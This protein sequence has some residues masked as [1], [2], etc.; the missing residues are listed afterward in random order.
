MISY[1][2]LILA[3]VLTAG[4]LGSTQIDPNNGLHIN[5]FSADPVVA[6]ADDVVRLLLDIENIGGTTAECVTAELFGVESWKDFNGAPLSYARPW[7]HHGISFGLSGDSFNFCYYDAVQG[8]ICSGYTKDYGVSFSSFFGGSF[9]SFSEDLC[10]SYSM[11]GPY[12]AITKT[13]PQLT[14]P[15]PE[16]NKPGQSII[17]EWILRPPALSEGLRVNYPITARTSYFY[18]SNAHMNIRVFNK[19]EFRRR[20]TIGEPISFPLEIVNTHASPIQVWAVDGPNPIIINTDP[21]I[22]G[23]DELENFRFQLVNTG[24]GFPLPIRDVD[25]PGAIGPDFESGFIFGTMTIS[26]PG[27]YF[28]DSFGQQGKEIILSGEILES[29]L[30]LRSDNKAPIGLTIGIDKSQW[31][32]TPTGTISITFNLWYR[33]Y[34]DSEVTVN[35]IGVEH[36]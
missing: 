1:A 7:R 12:D 2:T 5:E 15:L 32:G 16:R 22:G 28:Y 9:M 20:E 19:D 11:L 31:L 36:L 33:Y 8:E 10:R 18:T 17:A 24:Q 25:I 4:C 29:L 21:R 34:V 6:E 13:Y 26:G 14:P 3:V 35:V 23:P 27:A 30:K